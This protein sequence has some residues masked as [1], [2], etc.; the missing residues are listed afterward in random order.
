MLVDDGQRVR[1]HGF[2]RAVPILVQS[3]LLLVITQLVR[4]A[5][6]HVAASHARWI[7]QADQFQGFVKVGEAERNAASNGRSRRLAR[8]DWGRQD[9]L[10]FDSWGSCGARSSDSSPIASGKEK[11]FQSV[12][13]PGSDASSPV[14]MSA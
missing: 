7:H 4:Q 8:F 11:S 6:P 14:V 3:E 5:F 10:R 2:G 1:N 13:T 12:S 9:D